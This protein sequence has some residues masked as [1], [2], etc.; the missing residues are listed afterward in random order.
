MVNVLLRRTIGQAPAVSATEGS[1]P[2]PRRSSTDPPSNKRLR[3]G[4]RPLP[5]PNV[6]RRAREDIQVAGL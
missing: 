4:R 5:V 6:H 2:L 3:P 1:H